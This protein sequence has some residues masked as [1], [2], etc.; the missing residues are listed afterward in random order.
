M[1]EFIHFADLDPEP[2]SSWTGKSILSIDVDWAS[3]EVLAYTLD[4]IEEAGINACLFV[5]KG[6]HRGI[7]RCGSGCTCPAK[8]RHDNIGAV[9]RCLS[10]S[11]HYSLEQL[12]YVWW[13]ENPRYPPNQRTGRST[14]LLRR[15][16]LPLSA[17][18]W[19]S[20]FR[21]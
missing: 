13:L 9:A 8:S 4:L 7:E 10:R 16:R 1:T 18:S 5:S 11:R 12:P 19:Q 20:D 21:H 14:G 15:R 2:R 6:Y 17:G 3:D